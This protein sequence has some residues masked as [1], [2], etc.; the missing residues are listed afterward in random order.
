GRGLRLPFDENGNR[1]SDEEFYL[2][3]IIDYSE[4]EFA[5][6]LVG[7]INSDG[8]YLQTG[9]ITEHILELLVKAGYAP[10]KNAVFFKLGSEKIVDPEKNILDTEKLF[11]LLPDDS[12][13]K[14]K[15][16]KIT[17][18]GLP[19]K[20]KVRLNKANF[21][22]LRSLWNKVT[23][24]YLLH[25]EEVGEEKLKEIF[26]EVL[27]HSTIFVEPTVQ[28]I[29]DVLVRG[30][31]SVEMATEGYK[32]AKSGLGKIPYG[33]FLKRLNK[34]TNLPVPLLHKSIVSARKDKKTPQ[35]LF[36]I[37]SFNNIIKAFEKKFEEVFAQKFS[38]HALDFRANTSI[39]SGNDEFKEFLSQG[40]VGV[41]EAKELEKIRP[42]KANY[43]YDKYLYDSEIEHEI[44]RVQPSEKIIVY[45][46]LPRRSIKLPTYTGGTTSPDF[47]YAIKNND[48]DDIK[49]HLIVETKSENMR[50]S[51]RIAIEA[52]QKAFAKIG[53]NI[54]WKMDADFG[55]TRPPFR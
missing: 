29:E 51:D 52:Q 43:L 14:V 49:L 16:G 48:S 6:K 34:Q 12:G 55:D 1:I 44:L 7:E 19:E 41:N 23:K 21:E 10:D 47:V 17:G 39:L 2:T 18:E 4:R 33:E 25:F 22:K 35:E 20:P 31:N 3:Y 32:S 5:R 42:D 11:A 26:R 27:S 15:A 37:V 28:I 40:D 36:N 53:G 9:K 46:K 50:F 45:G 38:Y 30:E 54:E 13:L 24:R 8:G